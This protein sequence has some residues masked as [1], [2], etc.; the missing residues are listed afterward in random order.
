MKGEREKSIKEPL[1]WSERRERWKRRSRQ[2]K[3][4]TGEKGRMRERE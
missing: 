1:G 2:T 3:L 4:E